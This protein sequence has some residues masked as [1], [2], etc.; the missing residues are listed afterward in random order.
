MRNRV[1]TQTLK[2][3]ARRKARDICL[4]F[5]VVVVLAL[6]VIVPMRAKSAPF[7]ESVE[8][9]GRGDLE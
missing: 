5:F 3:I 8:T 4:V 6:L 7:A 9:M 2:D 1:R